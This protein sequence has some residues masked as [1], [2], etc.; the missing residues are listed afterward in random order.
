MGA[1]ARGGGSAGTGRESDGSAGLL[2]LRRCSAFESTRPQG[3]GAPDKMETAKNGDQMDRP[4]T[5]NDIEAFSR[6]P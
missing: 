4:Y 5:E 3:D 2:R 6:D 1:R